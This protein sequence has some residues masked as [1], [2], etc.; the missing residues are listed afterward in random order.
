ME[1]NKKAAPKVG[2]DSLDCLL[3]VGSDKT[4]H[5][6]AV[7]L[8]KV[9]VFRITQCLSKNANQERRYIEHLGFNP[10]DSTKSCCRAIA[11][12]NLSDLRQ[13]TA[14][15]LAKFGLEARCVSPDK[16]I[17][18]GYGEDTNQKLWAL[19]EINRGES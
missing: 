12:V 5:S 2:G 6:T 10:L 4:E 14:K 17:K 9:Q 3:L 19:Y 16:P 15:V 11:C 18:N 1:F 7:R 13:R 8:N